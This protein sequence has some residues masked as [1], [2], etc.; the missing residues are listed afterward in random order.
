MQAPDPLANP[1]I[2][3]RDISHD[4]VIPKNAPLPLS[5]SML[6]QIEKKTKQKLPISF[7]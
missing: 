6:Y 3:T 7:P 1:S 5:I 4:P 2:I